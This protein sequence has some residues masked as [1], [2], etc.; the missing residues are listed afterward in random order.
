M[1][2]APSC[3][4]SAAPEK[5]AAA[6]AAMAALGRRLTGALRL[7]GARPGW[8]AAGL[9]GLTW[10]QFHKNLA[11]VEPPHQL[12]FLHTTLSRSGL[13]EFFDDP[14]NWGEKTVKSGDAWNI[15]Q[16]RGKSS[17]DLHKLWYV[18]LKEKNML[19]TLEQ[20]SKRQQRPMPSPERLEKVQKSMKNIDLVVKERE[21][22][23]RLLQTG[24]EKPVPGEW[25]NDFLGRTY[26]YTYKEWPIP[27]YLNKKYKKRKFFYLPH[28]NHFIRLRLEKYLRVRARR[29]SLEKKRQKVLHMKFP[30]L[31][32]KSQS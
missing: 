25:R 8:A 3:A 14:K 12:K 24:H 10:N 30:H 19:L 1:L 31:A 28:V 18:L 4:T 6:A 15:K 32:V 11:K 27:W 26:W 21:T 23:L 13:E 16:L 29:Q 20:E 17:K 22:A 9:P 5:M 2:P 7:A